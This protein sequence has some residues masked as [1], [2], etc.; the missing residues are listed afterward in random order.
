MDVNLFF[1]RKHW[2]LKHSSQHLSPK[3]Q[4]ELFRA[5][6]RAVYL[7]HEDVPPHPNIRTEEASDSRVTQDYD[8]SRFPNH[9]FLPQR[10][11]RQGLSLH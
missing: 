9:G 11:I 1:S 6:D 5:Q 7:S 3:C 4:Q 8:G 2:P 10:K